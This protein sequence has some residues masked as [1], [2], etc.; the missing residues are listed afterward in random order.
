[1]GTWA[2]V[3]AISS[4]STSGRLHIRARVSSAP[5]WRRAFHGH[6][7][8]RSRIR[9]WKSED[10]AHARADEHTLTSGSSRTATGWRQSVRGARG[11]RGR[12]RKRRRSSDC[13]ARDTSQPSHCAER[14]SDE[15]T[16]TTLAPAPQQAPTCPVSRRP[17]ERPTTPRPPAHCAPSAAWNPRPL[18]AAAAGAP[19]GRARAAG[20]TGARAGR[21][22][23]PGG[24]RGEGVGRDAGHRRQGESHRAAQGRHRGFSTT[25]EHGLG[26]QFRSRHE[27]LV[28]GRIPAIADLAKS[29]GA[30]ASSQR[31][32]RGRR[33]HIP[34]P[35]QS[36]NAAGAAVAPGA[37]ELSPPPPGQCSLVSPPRSVSASSARAC[38]DAPAAAPIP[39][40]WI[41]LDRMPALVSRRPPAC[42][43]QVRRIKQSAP[44]LL[45]IRH[46]Y[47]RALRKGVHKLPGGGPYSLGVVIG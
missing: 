12:P 5:A 46:S 13:A 2:P 9:T 23:R 42:S 21:R 31:G 22:S 27:Q 32:R 38:G 4:L 45:V 43:H 10:R 36:A 33:G 19:R 17:R 16:N 6:Q 39:S 44:R 20:G 15:S 18:Y 24:H 28:R 11:G 34:G 41:Q 25:N 29:C 8:A 7:G 37:S 14:T 47:R 3:T 30:R 40:L 26:L 35:C 1:M